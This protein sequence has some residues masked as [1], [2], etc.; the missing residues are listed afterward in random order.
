M[1]K[2]KKC[3]TS[4]RSLVR[5]KGSTKPSKQEQSGA[6]MTEMRSTQ[7]TSNATREALNARTV[8]VVSESQ[9]IERAVRKQMREFEKVMAKEQRDLK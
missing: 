2:R 7:P 3:C 5:K 1:S 9:R 6:S 8:S 4:R